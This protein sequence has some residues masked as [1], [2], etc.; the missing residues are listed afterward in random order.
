M[1][2][3]GCRSDISVPPFRLA[4]GAFAGWD[5]H[6]L[7]SAASSR[8]TPKAGTPNRMYRSDLLYLFE[9]L[10]VAGAVPSAFLKAREKAAS[11]P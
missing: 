8:R 7:E 9:R 5:L 3:G 1:W 4:A 6:P 2:R 10:Q 11:E